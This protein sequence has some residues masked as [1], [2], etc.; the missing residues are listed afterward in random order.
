L[1]VVVVQ[2]VD[3][4]HLI[5]L[6]LRLAAENEIILVI[7]AVLVVLLLLALEALAEQV[8]EILDK[9]MPHPA[10]AVRVGILVLVVLE[11]TL[12]VLLVRQVQAAVAAAA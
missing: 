9:L 4:V 10:V 12:L 6:Q 7:Q 1:E 5:Q 2:T 8:V 11:Q 3:V